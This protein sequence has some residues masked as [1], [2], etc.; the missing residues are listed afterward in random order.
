[1]GLYDNR[2]KMC[3]IHNIRVAH[4]TVNAG[5][6]LG[7]YVP[8]YELHV[9]LGMHHALGLLFFFFYKLI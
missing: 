3:F 2:S 1:M 6:L 5:S 4:F 9:H 8:F 7:L